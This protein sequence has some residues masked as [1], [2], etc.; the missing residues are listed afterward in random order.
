[1][2]KRKDTTSNLRTLP[3]AIEVVQGFWIA[4]MP[5]RGKGSGT[6]LRCIV[7]QD[8]NRGKVLTLEDILLARTGFDELRKRGK[9]KVRDLL[10]MVPDGTFRQDRS[11][12]SSNVNEDLELL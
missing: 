10:A 8:P 9:R 12:S 5:T 2:A 3:G 4:R 7:G 11:V 6:V 1:M